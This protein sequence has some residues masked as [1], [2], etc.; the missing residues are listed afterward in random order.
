MIYLGIYWIVEGDIVMSFSCWVVM[1]LNLVAI[2]INSIGLKR[3]NE[4][5]R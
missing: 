4:T 1:L 5:R 3:Y 2:W